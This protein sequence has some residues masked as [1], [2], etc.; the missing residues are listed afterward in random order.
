[1]PV[2]HE[3][4]WLLIFHHQFT[5]LLPSNVPDKFI[6]LIIPQEIDVVLIV[7]IRRNEQRTSSIWI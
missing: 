6:T 5:A 7:V 3:I 2:E 4:V 1:M